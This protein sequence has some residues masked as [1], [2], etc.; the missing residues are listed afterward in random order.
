MADDSLH[1]ISVPC[2]QCKACG[3]IKPRS[4][5]YIDKRYNSASGSCKPCWIKK[6]TA[7]AKA[8]PE[9]MRKWTKKSVHKNAA[10]RR[11]RLYMWKHRNPEKVRALARNKS[12]STKLKGLGMTEA[13]LL[14]AYEAQGRKCAICIEPIG[15]EPS[16]QVHIDHC[17]KTNR[18]RGVLC[19]KCNTGIGKFNDSPERLERAAAYVAQFQ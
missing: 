15:I 4:E 1:D 16:R 8:N 3:E 11:A 12:R 2:K 13:E 5:F 18:F 6:T 7:Y 9:K 14:A 10:K 19:L 17:H